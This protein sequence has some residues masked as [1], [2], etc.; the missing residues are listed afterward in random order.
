MGNHG[1]VIVIAPILTVSSTV[2]YTVDD[3]AIWQSCLFSSVPALTR[4]I[5]V[6]NGWD[7]KRFLLYGRR[8][9]SDTGKEESILVQMNFDSAFTGGNCTDAHGDYESWTAVNEHGECALGVHTIVKRRKQGHACSYLEETVHETVERPCPCDEDDYECDHCFYRPTLRSVCTLECWVDS[10]PDKPDDCSP[11]SFYEVD[12]GYR[13]EAGNGCDPHLPGARKPKALVPCN[14]AIPPGVL[15]SRASPG[16][17]IAIYLTIAILF[18]VIVCILLWRFNKGFYHRV[19]DTLGVDNCLG[20][21]DHF[22]EINDNFDAE[23]DES[24]VNLER[25]DDDNHPL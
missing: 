5:R 20:R 2:T 25:S 12:M 1:A 6:S 9:N 8:N 14:F 13:K 19:R 16:F 22:E 7:S 18:I 3:G 17:L 4:N 10:L 21:G 11:S 23:A 15:A 24:Q